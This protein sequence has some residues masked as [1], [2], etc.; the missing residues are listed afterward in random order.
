MRK[1]P[2]LETSFVLFDTIKAAKAFVEAHDRRAGLKSS[3]SVNEAIIASSPRFLAARPTP[4]KG[5]RKCTISMGMYT[6]PSSD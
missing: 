5:G 1:K 3:S 4:S 2:H 6:G